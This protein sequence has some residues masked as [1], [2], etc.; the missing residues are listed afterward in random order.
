MSII[1]S[2]SGPFPQEEYLPQ[3]AMHEPSGNYPYINICP[4]NNEYSSHQNTYQ[5]DSDR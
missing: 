1:K 5:I 3:V 2:E 4:E